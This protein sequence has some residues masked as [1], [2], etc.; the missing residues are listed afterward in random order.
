MKLFQVLSL[1]LLLSLPVFSGLFAQ[2]QPA[3]KNQTLDQTTHYKWAKLELS[4]ITSM[5]LANRAK[6]LFEKCDGIQSTEVDIA[7]HTVTL[8]Y[9]AAVTEPK[10][11]SKCL[12]N[13]SFS[14]LKTNDFTPSLNPKS[15]K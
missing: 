3:S 7:T 13:S 6:L 15:T 4:G 5:A 11:F 8:S 1:S 10:N 9:D 12:A 2:N 14:I